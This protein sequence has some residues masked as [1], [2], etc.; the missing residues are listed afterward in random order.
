MVAEHTAVSR[1]PSSV[2]PK[3]APRST[4]LAARFDGADVS[5]CAWLHA[6][7][8][9]I[10]SVPVAGGGKSAICSAIDPDLW[11]ETDLLV[12]EALADPAICE[13][14]VSDLPMADLPVVDRVTTAESQIPLEVMMQGSRVCG[15]REKGVLSGV[16]VEQLK[17]DLAGLPGF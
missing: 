5:A 6:R 15:L 11:T 17:G 2:S 1:R 13:R 9:N 3:R 4:H 14:L 10:G 8:D 12:V 16:Q 7:T